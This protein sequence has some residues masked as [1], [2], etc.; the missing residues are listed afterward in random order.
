MRVEHYGA[1][2]PVVA[3]S[4]HSLVNA[5]W[6]AGQPERALEY[7]ERALAIKEATY[8]PEHPKVASSLVAS[9]VTSLEPAAQDAPGTGALRLKVD[10]VTA[11]GPD[12]RL[13]N[14]SFQQPIPE[15]DGDLRNNPQYEEI[16]VFDT[17]GQEIPVPYQTIGRRRVGVRE[18]RTLRLPEARPIGRI[19]VRCLRK[20]TILKRSVTFPELKLP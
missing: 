1:E 3:D 14:I 13:V 20:Y 5:Y 9:E 15:G 18:V 16:L 7:S 19:V 2:H 12:Q 6:R 10:S 4:Y 17:K 11:S 8:G